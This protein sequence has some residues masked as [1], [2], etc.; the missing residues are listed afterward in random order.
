VAGSSS[1]LEEKIGVP[2][3]KG[4]GCSLHDLI[5]GAPQ[6]HVVND[7]GVFLAVRAGTFTR[8][9]NPAFVVIFAGL[10]G[11]INADHD[12]GQLAAGHVGAA[13]QDAAGHHTAKLITSANAYV[14]LLETRPDQC[15]DIEM[16]ESLTLRCGLSAGHTLGPGQ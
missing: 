10:H 11:R 8:H 2:L 6:G 3:V 16:T 15:T 12:P 13:Q 7:E 5:R 9:H 1:I 4:G 14:H